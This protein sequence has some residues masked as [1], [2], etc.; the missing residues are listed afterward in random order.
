[1]RGSGVAEPVSTLE[2]C[3]GVSASSDISRRACM[4]GSIGVPVLLLV[5]LVLWF[6]WVVVSLTSDASVNWLAVA[7][8][9]LTLLFGGE[10]E[11]APAWL[12]WTSR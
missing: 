7:W 8:A 10:R 4:A 9:W 5:G 12:T 1:M 2:E 6:L 11:K 3:S